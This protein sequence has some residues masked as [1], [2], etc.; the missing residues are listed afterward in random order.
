MD[1][2]TETVL[3][4]SNRFMIVSRYRYRP[5]IVPLP[6]SGHRD[7]W[8]HSVHHRYTP[9]PHR[10]SLSPPS[11][12]VPHRPSPFHT[13]LH[14]P[15]PFFTVPQG[16]SRKVGDSEGR[17]C[18]DYGLWITPAPIG[19]GTVTVMGQNHYFHSIILTKI[20]K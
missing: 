2:E 12:T 6:F 16:R 8:S 18:H 15:S 4:D 9:V 7:P 17:E 5:I 20:L 19:N 10:P 14:R 11:R 13:V 3:F 1:L